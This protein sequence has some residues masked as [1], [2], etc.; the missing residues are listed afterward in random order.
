MQ[1]FEVMGN[2]DEKGQLLLDHP[3]QIQK[4]SRVKIILLV[5]EDEE[6]E[7]DTSATIQASLK[8]ALQEVA[9]G[10]TRPVS[11]LWTGIDD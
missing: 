2:I 5:T 11:E 6:N 10:K 4:P 8:Q 9:V 7:L 1:A 3:I